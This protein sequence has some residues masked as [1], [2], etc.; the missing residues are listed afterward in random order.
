MIWFI[1]SILTA[2]SVS[3]QDIFK[4]KALQ[5]MD[6]YIF[7]W[8]M[9]LFSMIFIFP[10]LFI[11]GIPHLWE[12]F[13]YALIV[14]WLINT[15]TMI[16]YVKA[17]QESDLSLISPLVTFT[18][19]FLLISSPL[20]VN[21][22]PSLYSIIWV[23][24][25]V[26]WAYTLNIKDRKKSLFKPIKSLLSDSWARKM[27]L[28]A[29][30]WSISSNF[31]KVWVLNSSPIFWVISVNIFVLIMLTPIIYYKSKTKVLEIIPNYK[32]FIIISV[33]HF[34]WLF[35]QMTAISFMSVIYVI[36]IKRLSA[37]FSVIFWHI[38]FKE[39]NIRDRLIWVIIMIIWVIFITLLK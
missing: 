28:V 21:E 18:P 16:L 13:Y 9:S 2:L 7:T 35:L 15:A 26:I 29:F 32:I 23:F 25:L 31:D 1:L 19:L 38:I 24:V 27:F 14:S 17:M 10:L 4:K 33:I 36:A 22:I 8:G 11:T 3:I 6:N 12:N 34:L 39:K 30:L 37:V 5:N 20:I